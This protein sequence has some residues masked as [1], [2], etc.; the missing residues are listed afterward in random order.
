MP[1]PGPAGSVFDPHPIVLAVGGRRP[2]PLTM[3][4]RLTAALR[5]M[6]LRACDAPG[7]PLPE[8]FTGHG[9]DGRPS[10]NPHMALVPLPWVGWP[11]SDGTIAGLAVLPP[12]GHDPREIRRV[13]RPALMDGA[14]GTARRNR[15]F[16]GTLFDCAVVHDDREHLPADLDPR[17]WTAVSR[18]WASVTPVVLDRH[19]DGRDRWHRAAESVKDMC[20]RIG[21]P[22]AGEVL[23]QPVSLVEGVPN[24]R[25]FPEMARRGDGGRRAQNHA[26]VIFDEPVAGPLLLGAG[27]FRGYGLCRAL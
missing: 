13:L 23:L 1:P 4:I 12:R 17:P 11:H 9:P 16:D 27:R 8:W 6:L 3:T 21:L 5:G 15:L 14:T 2:V 25:D 26:V 18:A 20:V 22:R 7:N 19:F 24:A 10:A